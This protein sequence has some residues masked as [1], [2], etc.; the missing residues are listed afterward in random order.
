MVDI[1]KGF[2]NIIK[3]TIRTYCNMEN[4]FPMYAGTSLTRY[5]KVM[6]QIYLEKKN[7]YTSYYKMDHFDKINFLIYK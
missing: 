3:K 7:N 1:A 4:V 6:G 2:I 5:K